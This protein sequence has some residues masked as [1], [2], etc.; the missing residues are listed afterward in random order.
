M[1]KAQL[2]TNTLKSK[3]DKNIYGHFSE[4]L[5]RC[6]Y[7]GLY[8]GENSDIPNVDGMRLDVVEALKAV[9]IPVLRWPGGCFADEYHWM[10]GIGP[11]NER[12]SMINTNWGGVTEDNSFGTHE[13]LRLCELLGCEPYING[14]LGSGTVREMSQWVEYLNSDNISPM[15]E[16]RKKNG[17][18]K[19]WGVKYFAVGNENWGCGGNMRP[20]YYADEYRRYATYCRNYGDNKLVKVACG[21][22]AN[23]FKWTETIMRLCRGHMDALSLHNYVWRWK[24]SATEIDDEKYFD[25]VRDALSMEF[26]VEQ[27]SKIM[28]QYDPGKRIALF[29]DEWGAWYKA[30]E[31]TNPGFLYQQNTMRDSVVAASILNI[32]NNHSDRVRMSNIAQVV[33]VIQA[34]I[35][36]EGDKMLKTPTYHIYDLY[37]EHQDA[38]LIGCDILE[39]DEYS[40]EMRRPPMP[41][42]HE[43][44]HHPP[45]EI[46][47]VNISATRAED[48]SICATLCNVNHEKSISCSLSL[49]GNSYSE[50]SARIL[51]SERY[52]DIN[53]FEEPEKITLKPF[54]TNLSGSEITFELPPFSTFAL[55]I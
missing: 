7:G 46:K 9:K 24:D 4:H 32:F 33:N 41:P 23:D 13:F 36:T 14:N 17:R 52:D 21:P 39:N 8:V 16:L 30:M 11:K 26:L 47:S 53:T 31:G 38:T 45:K 29:V 5:G 15:T 19:S 50:V 37:K 27:H 44:H 40:V 49:V 35:L 25:V 3:V 42:E 10:D 12:P 28:D 22:N 20:E 43:G 1:F 55:I 54:T 51:T 34:L 18:E 48:G 2:N 6:I